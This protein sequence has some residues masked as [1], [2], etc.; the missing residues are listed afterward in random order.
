VSHDTPSVD[1]EELEHDPSERKPG[2]PI[3]EMV[4][5]LGPRAWR[6]KWAGPGVAFL[7]AMLVQSAGLHVATHHYVLRMAQM[8]NARLGSSDGASLA[9]QFVIQD[10][11]RLWLVGS[12]PGA[13]GSTVPASATGPMR[14]FI[15]FVLMALPVLWVYAT[16]R[17]RNLR[18]WTRTLVVACLLALLKGCLS[19]ATVF[20]DPAGWDTCKERLFPMALAHY[21]HRNIS[22]GLAMIVSSLDVVGLWIQD[23]LFSMR[24]Q[25]DFICTKGISGPSYL[26]AVCCL[27]LFDALRIEW[28][29]KKPHFRVSYHLLA[30]GF[31]TALVL[32]DG[33]MAVVNAE[34]HSVD[35]ALALVL[36]LLFYSNPVIAICA[37]RWMTLGC[38]TTPELREGYDTG[39]VI[40]PPCCFPFCWVHGRYF[41]FT[42]PASKAVEARRQQEEER[43]AQEEATRVAEEY[44][45]E[46]EEATRRCIELQAQLASLQQRANIR[47]RD[48]AAEAVRRMN[49]AVHDMHLAHEARV[50]ASLESLEEKLIEEREEGAQLEKH[51][52]DEIQKLVAFQERCASEL[53]RLD[54]EASAAHQEVVAPDAGASPSSDCTSPANTDAMRA[55]GD[56]SRASTDWTLAVAAPSANTAPAVGD[57]RRLSTASWEAIHRR[58]A[59]ASPATVA[60]PS[61]SEG[62]SAGVADVAVRA[63]PADAWDIVHRRLPART[64]L[65]EAIPSVAVPPLLAEVALRTMPPDSWQ[66]LHARFP[67]RPR[68]VAVEAQM[69]QPPASATS[70]GGT[71]TRS[72]PPGAWDAVHKRFPARVPGSTPAAAAASSALP[73]HSVAAQRGDARVMPPS[74]WAAIHAHF[75]KDA[76]AQGSDSMST[77]SDAK[78]IAEKAAAQVDRAAVPPPMVAQTGGLA[79]TEATDSQVA[80]GPAPRTLEPFEPAAGPSL[81]TVEPLDKPATVAEQTALASSSL[82]APAEAEGAPG[83]VLTPP[84]TDALGAPEAA[85]GAEALT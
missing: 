47:E 66:A 23:I 26:S 14:F 32:C 80:T 22:T 19:F 78:G 17:T 53:K 67:S 27:G 72:I 49:E 69:P 56:A 4:R 11:L 82:A 46:Q 34:Q 73:V 7:G 76:P 85:A 13:K 79:E 20:P 51:V 24:W 33:F 70:S 37:D 40:V 42:T 29:K 36:A 2:G 44:R 60:P 68:P 30:A 6:H 61:A 28:R 84:E 48:L 21:Q 31:L 77:M 55:S 58:F 50:A 74:A 1:Y 16:V 64:L 9:S 5:A 81:T 18:L 3:V 15:H 10:Q 39:D 38:T 43:R 35:V 25:Q 62:P 45:I 59:A 8:E 12:S 54:E 52:L 75:A 65:R 63:M 41:L 83:V 57:A 71:K